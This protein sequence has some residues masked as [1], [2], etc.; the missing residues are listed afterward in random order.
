MDRIPTPAWSG[1][2]GGSLDS[3]TLAAGLSRV[4]AELEDLEMEPSKLVDHAR[5]WLDQGVDILGVCCGLTAR[6][7]AALRAATG[8]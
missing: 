6:H 4:D 5:V 1:L 7:V 8:R 2:P 3:S